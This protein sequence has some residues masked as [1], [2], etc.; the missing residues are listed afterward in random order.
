[1]L[2][3]QS[4]GFAV[5]RFIA[6]AVQQLFHLADIEIIGQSIGW[7]CREDIKQNQNHYQLFHG[8]P[9]LVRNRS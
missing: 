9:P 1:M 2:P 3:T 7:R 5:C 6:V 4:H 8:F